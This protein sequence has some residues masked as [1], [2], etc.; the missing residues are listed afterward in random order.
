MGSP[1]REREILE[2]LKARDS[3]L[4]TAPEIA[5]SLDVDRRTIRYHT[6]KKEQ[7]LLGDRVGGVTVG[8]AEG[9]YLLEDD[10][11]VTPPASE[12]PDAE[13]DEEEEAEDR[14][15][16]PTRTIRSS[17]HDVS[18]P[19]HQRALSWVQTALLVVLTL[20]VVGG[21]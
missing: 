2:Y 19:R 9:L 20:W 21:L 6:H 4:V 15:E 13:E 3:V 1:D 16:E 17:T 8:R 7:P 18:L 10:P 11:F 12:L 14:A 5:E